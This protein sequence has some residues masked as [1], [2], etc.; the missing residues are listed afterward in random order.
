MVQGAAESN[1][2]AGL[3][4]LTAGMDVELPMPSCYWNGLKAK[5]ESGEADPAILDAAVLHVLTAKFRMGLFEHPFALDEDAL[6]AVTQRQE[7]DEISR[8]RQ[9]RVITSAATRIFPWWRRCTQR[10]IRWR[11]PAEAAARQ[12]LR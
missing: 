6:T 2:D 4:C 1:A 10:P 9:T 5:F 7:D 12:A 11:E 8:T 3:K